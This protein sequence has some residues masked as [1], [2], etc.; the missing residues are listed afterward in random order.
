MGLSRLGSSCGISARTLSLPRLCMAS[1]RIWLLRVFA[2]I[3]GL[4]VLRFRGR[5]GERTSRSIEVAQIQRMRVVCLPRGE[6]NKVMGMKIRI[7]ALHVFV[8]VRL[9]LH[10]GCLPDHTRR[11]HCSYLHCF[12]VHIVDEPDEETTSLLPSR[13]HKQ[14]G[15]VKTMSS[16]TNPTLHSRN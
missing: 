6:R 15:F 3:W 13:Y 2:I 4:I 10:D 7:P 12:R 1:G 11:I 9:V 8:S 5:V 16:N 14:A